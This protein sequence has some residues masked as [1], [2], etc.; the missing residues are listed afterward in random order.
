MAT[1]FT[2]LTIG[3][4]DRRANA[5]RAELWRTVNAVGRWQVVLRNVGGIYN[6]VFD[7]QNAFQID[8]DIGAGGTTMMTGSVDGPGVV[9]RG[10][11]AEDD[12]E[13]LIILSGVDRMQDFLFH[14]DFEYYYPNSAQLLHNV[15]NDIINVRLAGLTNIT[16]VAPGASPAIGATE[17]KEG[18]SFLGTLQEIYRRAGWIFYVD[19]L[20]VLEDGAPGFDASGD[21]FRSVAGAFNNNIIGVVDF[22]ERDGDKLYNYIKLYGKN[23]MFDAYT[24]LNSVSWTAQPAGNILDDTTIVRVGTYSQCVYN[25]NPANT[26]LRHMLTAPVF[27]YANWNFTKGEIGFWGYYDDNAGAPPAVG[28]PGAGAAGATEFAEIVLT[29]STGAFVTFFGSGTGGGIGNTLLYEEEWGWCYAQ[30]GGEYDNTVANVANKWCQ[31][32]GATFDWADVTQIMF[33][34]PRDAL[35]SWPSHFYIDGITMPV[36]PIAITSN[37]PSV[38]RRRPFIDQRPEIRTQNALDSK[39]TQLLTHHEGSGV[40][41]I[42]FVVEGTTNLRYAG[43][44]FDV[45]IPS[46]GINTVVFYATQIHHIIEPYVDVSDGYGFDFITEVEAVPTSGV[47]FDMGRLRDGPLYSSSQMASRDGAG[48]RVK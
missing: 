27:N 2:D 33:R 44:S 45:N 26:R 14:N 21:V 5:V 10:Q 28:G 38:Y 18:T 30:L 16:Y 34:M 11:D 12:W 36:P 42:K 47:A 23:P 19:D 24:E 8:I 7:I 37:L 43:Q 15:V 17:F 32:G 48:L 9:L 20:L 1:Q 41:F 40:E 4:A 25:N 3:A 46:L 22:K 29:D 35:N 6:G 39:A 13:E 31:G